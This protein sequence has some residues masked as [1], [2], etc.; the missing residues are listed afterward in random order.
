MDGILRDLRLALRG[1]WRSPGFAA[2]AILSIGLGVGANTTVFAWIDNIV[3]H[4]FPA[5]PDGG[6]L[7][8]LNVADHEGRLDGMPPMSLPILDEWLKG[9]ASFSGVAAHAHALATAK[10]PL[11]PAAVSVT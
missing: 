7:V 3:R 1:L 10:V 4:P 5:I 8:A 6:T 2:S 9:T 11:P